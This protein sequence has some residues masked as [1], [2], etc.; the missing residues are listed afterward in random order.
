MQQISRA[1]SKHHLTAGSPSA[2]KETQHSSLAAPAE[3]SHDAKEQKNELSAEMWDED[4]E[5]SDAQRKYKT[6]VTSLSERS[7]DY[8]HHIQDDKFLYQQLKYRK[9]VRSS[10]TDAHHV[11]R[12]HNRHAMM[13]SG[14]EFGTSL[15]GR[16]SSFGVMATGLPPHLLSSRLHH[17]FPPVGERWAEPVEATAALAPDSYAPIRVEARAAKPGKGNKDGQLGQR[18]AVDSLTQHRAVSD[19]LGP[20]SHNPVPTQMTLH[21]VGNLQF[22]SQARVTG[23]TRVAAA[24]K[25]NYE[26]TLQP[27]HSGFSMSRASRDIT[28]MTPAI[29]M[30]VPAPGQYNPQP[31]CNVAYVPQ[32][33]IKGK[34][35]VRA[36]SD[37]PSTHVTSTC[38][39]IPLC[40]VERVYLLPKLAVWGSTLRPR[41]ALWAPIHVHVRPVGISPR[42]V[43]MGRRLRLLARARTRLT[44][45]RARLGRLACPLPRRRSRSGPSWRSRSRRPSRSGCSRRVS[46]MRS[47]CARR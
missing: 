15:Q 38:C 32:A 45:G 28:Q 20:G 14:R 5:L 19:K 37:L 26:I 41:A 3:D 25:A 33:A 4:E 18:R 9:K 24:Q 11:P 17:S 7:L 35:Y 6:Y 10:S 16:I 8:L 2:V 39:L 12:K 23:V 44:S 40:E 30:N 22:N 1:P 47:S 46:R 27:S 29:R 43:T 13:Y 21:N 42:L 31:L 36:H 34:G